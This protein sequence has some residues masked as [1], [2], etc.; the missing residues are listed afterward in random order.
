[1]SSLSDEPRDA[2]D[3]VL[4]QLAAAL[5]FEGVVESTAVDG[6]RIWT[7]G[8]RSWRCR[9]EDGPFGRPRVGP[10]DALDVSGRWAPAAIE[11]LLDALPGGDAL[12]EEVLRTVALCR[13]NAAHLERRP[14]RGL[15]LDS[16]DPALDEG[17]PYHP[18]F[19]ARTGFS[20]D[21]HR[22]YGPEAGGTFQLWWLAAERGRLSEALPADEAAF[23][24][25][26]IGADAHRD[27]VA[28]M[29]ERGLDLDRHGLCPLHPW[30]RERLAEPIAGLVS[31]GGVYDLGQAGPHYRATQSVRTL[32]VAG[33][34]TRPHVKLSLGIG[35]TSALRTL[36]P[37]SITVAPALSDWLARLVARDAAFAD[38]Y[39]L[40]ILKEH[41][42]VALDRAG[43]LGG[44]IAAIWRES[45]T[46]AL[47]TGE[48]AAPFN[49]L[50]AIESD[51]AAFVDPWLRAHGVSRWVDRLIEIAVMPVW[52][53]LVTHGVATEAHGQNMILVHRAGWPE[54]LILRDFHDSVEVVPGF[55]AEPKGFPDFAALDPAYL[56][57]P[58]NRFFVMDEVE[59]L[60]ALVMDALFV[61]NLTE[62]SGLLARRYAF[63]EA[64]FW[65]RVG[66]RIARYAVE[67]R[68][69][70]RQ[71]ALGWNAPEIAVERLLARKLDPSAAPFRLVPNACARFGAQF[72]EAS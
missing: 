22:L 49:A 71:A 27:L 1:M 31:G 8:G 9:V 45:P 30:Q 50:F 65:R 43:P 29:A 37:H 6:V 53:L 18:S 34:P 66:A 3:R 44:E 59:E 62:L 26:A 57:A 12:R 38:R 32:G 16:L 19:K 42:A 36:D 28:R 51:G 11:P 70:A 35:V 25:D 52:R 40:T 61:F 64:E 17:H 68:E 54:R 55:L 58:P 63:P 5:I 39:P 4:R 21:D 60:R 41:A 2:E 24:T 15:P 48:A 23:W 56:D 13:W 10:V 47:R 20:D 69:E 33:E 7:L 67:H 72:R 46:A 14:R